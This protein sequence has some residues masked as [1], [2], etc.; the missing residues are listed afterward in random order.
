L[1]RTT[2]QPSLADLT[3]KLPGRN[4]KEIRQKICE[5]KETSRKFYEERGL[6]PPKWC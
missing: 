4:E 3:E 2:S 1:I 5:L 6:I